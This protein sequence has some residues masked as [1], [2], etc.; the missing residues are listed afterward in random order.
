MN[1]NLFRQ[2]N[3]NEN[4]MTCASRNRNG[5]SGGRTRRMN[6]PFTDYQISNYYNLDHIIILQNNYNYIVVN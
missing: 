2:L 4:I 1:N 5:V 6:I 3:K